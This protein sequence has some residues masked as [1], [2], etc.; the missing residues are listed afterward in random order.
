MPAILRRL[1][2]MALALLAARSAAGYSVLTHE[3]II[4]SVWKGPFQR[5]LKKRFPKTSAADLDAALAYAYGGCIIQEMG[6]YPFGSH[7]FS[8]LVHYIR[9]GD[10]VENM[11]RDA[12]DVN[13]YA[14]ALGSL[15][16]Y[17]ADSIGHPVAINRA[18]PVAYPKL[19]AEF[20][21]EVTYADK[22]SA[23]LKVEFGFDVLQVAR[24]R[25]APEAYL[26]F[27]GFEIA[28]DLL[29]RAFLKTYGEDLKD[30]FGSLD[31]ALGTYRYSVSTVI[32]K[33]T[34]VAWETKRKDIEKT[35]GVTR[36][37]FVYALPRADYERQWG[38]K[39]R[40]ARLAGEGPL[41]NA[42]HR[43]EGRT[44]S[45]PRFPAADARDGTDV[46]RQLRRHRRTL[47]GAAQPSGKRPARRRQHEPGHRPPGPTW[48]IQTGE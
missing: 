12:K 47:P 16:H 44:L 26:H 11:I 41:G 15:E 32:P 24:G 25:Y 17:V 20:G 3:A 2:G 33:L 29:K 27:V 21:N 10:F 43:A 5:A 19:R 38:K 40:R 6:Y 7:L 22:P 28:E 46:S 30:L 18:V 36:Q 1:A 39:Y 8:D 35:A 42:A 31:L 9:S 23:H 45:R 34:E 13:E 14:S 4:D 48:T 37:S